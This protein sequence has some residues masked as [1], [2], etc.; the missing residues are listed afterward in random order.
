MGDYPAK[1]SAFES[2][3]LLLALRTDVSPM[4][5]ELVSRFEKPFALESPREKA[6]GS[7]SFLPNGNAFVGWITGSQIAE[8]AL[9]GR[10]LMH[11]EFKR[12]EPASYRCYKMPWLVLLVYLFLEIYR[13]L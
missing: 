10:M 9:D 2:W 1:A 5:V 4:T 8:Y 13:R 11:A 12:P 3:G 6:R 7:V